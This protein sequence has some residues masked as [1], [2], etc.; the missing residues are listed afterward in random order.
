MPGVGGGKRRKE[1]HGKRHGR[2]DARH[3]TRSATPPSTIA[4]HPSAGPALR[5]R[6][7][8]PNAVPAMAKDAMT[9]YGKKTTSPMLDPVVYF[10]ITAWALGLIT[11]LGI[12]S[13]ALA[14]SSQLKP[15]EQFLSFG[16]TFLQ[17]TW[18][19]NGLHVLLAA[20][21]AL[22][23]YAALQPGL[24]KVFAIVFGGVYVLLGILGFFVFVGDNSLLA[25]TPTINIIH[26]LLGLWGLT[27][28]LL[29]PSDTGP[30]YAT[31]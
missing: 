14:E 3:A 29:A 20:T 10:R 21:A 24:V 22:F 1:E 8:N 5:E 19:H 28:G 27:A 4:L 15:S 25:L 6:L 18:W 11:L 7:A 9:E 12:I 23:G 30:R 26:L 16:G 31:P 17:F 2:K 13:T